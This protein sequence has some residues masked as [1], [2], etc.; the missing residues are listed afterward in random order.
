MLLS[1]NNLA[2]LYRNQV[3]YDQAET[4]YVKVLEGRRRTL[5]EQTPGCPDAWERF[6]SQSMPGELVRKRKYSRA[7]VAVRLL[8]SP[9][10]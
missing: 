1:T 6:N 5:G 10:R 7:A 9:R 3:K 8:R 2:T 4:L